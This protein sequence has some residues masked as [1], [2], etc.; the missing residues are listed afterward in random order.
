[1]DP[2]E[3][4]YREKFSKDYGWLSESLRCALKGR[5][6]D[7]KSLYDKLVAE[8]RETTLEQR[9]RKKHPSGLKSL[10]AYEESDFFSLFLNL[11]D[12]GKC[13]CVK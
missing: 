2:E 10:V 13:L 4:L 12:S 9:E 3:E 8:N 5:Q 7:Y 11:F 1:M 6:V